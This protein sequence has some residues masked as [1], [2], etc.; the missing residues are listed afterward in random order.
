MTTHQTAPRMMNLTLACAAGLFLMIGTTT[1]VLSAEEAGDKGHTA[2][3]KVDGCEKMCEE[4]KAEK[5]KLIADRNAQDSQLNAE[6]AAINNAPDD[7]KV[8]LIATVITHMV[9]QR[10]A[11]DAR[12]D[13]MEEDMMKHMMAHMDQG[14]EPATKCSMMKGIDKKNGEGHEDHENH[15]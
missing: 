10:I 4:M 5:A 11:M 15:K 6:I 1:H 14:K 2:A 7:K 9:A 8:S 12:K 3:G 13:K